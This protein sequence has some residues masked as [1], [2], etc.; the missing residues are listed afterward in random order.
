LE[1]EILEGTL[2]AKEYDKESLFQMMLTA[3]LIKRMI[4]LGHKYCVILC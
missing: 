4:H 3:M 2:D 1:E